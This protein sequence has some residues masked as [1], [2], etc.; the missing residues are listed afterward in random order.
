MQY[1]IRFECES[2]K[3]LNEM[4]TRFSEKDY[5]IIKHDKDS[6]STTGEVKREHYHMFL[7]YEDNTKHTKQNFI[8]IC[9]KEY[10]LNVHV[11]NV[12]SES[13]CLRYLLHLDNPEKFQYDLS[14]MKTNIED[15]KARMKINV[16]VGL[17]KKL[18]QVIDTM[19]QKSFRGLVEYCVIN[20]DTN[21]LEYI[22]VN[23]Y[24]VNA[25]LKY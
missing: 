22:Q 13:K 12:R 6:N 9:E 2:E 11:E 16:G 18:M 3:V 21:L 8:K 15:I 7:N 10:G 14:E 25:L 24:F 1:F 20:E 4:I 17:L 19:P 23:A 5:A